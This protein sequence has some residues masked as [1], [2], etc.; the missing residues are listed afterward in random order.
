MMIPAARGVDATSALSSEKRAPDAR[1]TSA[2]T[3]SAPATSA[4]QTR[5]EADRAAREAAMREAAVAFEATFLAE[6]LKHAGAGQSTPGFDGGVGEDA[7]A[8]ELVT[9]QARNIAEAGGIGLA[10]KLFEAMLARETGG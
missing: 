7:F 8:Q 2:P 5:A 6:M 3:T 9:A 1:A 4:D 10:E